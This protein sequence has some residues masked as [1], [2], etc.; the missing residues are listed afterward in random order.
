MPVSDSE[1]EQPAGDPLKD[2][3][4]EEQGR[5]RRRGAP[6]DAAARA[7]Q[8]QRER[9]QAED[10]RL[11]LRAIQKRDK[12]RVMDA[13]RKLGVSAEQIARVEKLW[14]KLPPK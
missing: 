10:E 13:L 9:D 11:L 4:A 8:R 5:R 7:S 6:L 1:R 14:S 2:V 3:I 12:R